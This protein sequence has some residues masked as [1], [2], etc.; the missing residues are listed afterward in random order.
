[1][2]PAIVLI[3]SLALAPAIFARCENLEKHPLAN[4]TWAEFSQKFATVPLPRGIALCYGRG[5]FSELKKGANMQS[6]LDRR[7]RR[8][9]LRR[10]S[11]ALL[12]HELAHLYLD[13]SWKVLP[14][15]VSEPLATALAKA[16]T[17]ELQKPRQWD[18]EV[19]RLRWSQMGQL[20]EC[21]VQQLFADVLGAGP[22]V[23]ERLPLR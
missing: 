21:E 9:V 5:Y 19:I 1:M 15:S 12:R 18:Y 14:Y 11:E 6:A 7:K 8:I 20:S 10:H 16:E 2:K 13:V 4:S 23:R 22:D 3:Y 17:C